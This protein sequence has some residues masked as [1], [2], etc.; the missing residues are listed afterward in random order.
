VGISLAIVAQDVAG[1]RRN[2]MEN[3][4][5]SNAERRIWLM[6]AQMMRRIRSHQKVTGH[7]KEDLEPRKY[8]H[9]YHAIIAKVRVMK[10]VVVGQGHVCHAGRKG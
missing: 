3:V 2:V 1:E 9:Q 6:S 10:T 8:D 7:H 4:L 5:A